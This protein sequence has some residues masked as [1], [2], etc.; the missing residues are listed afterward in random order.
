M[1]KNFLWIVLVLI[2]IVFI[3]WVTK[4]GNSGELGGSQVAGSITIAGSSSVQP[5]SEILAEKFMAQYTE[6]RVNV[7]GGGSSQGIES[8]KSGV[9]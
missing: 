3:T 6:A 5:F 2:L 7:Q 1:R 8:V 4:Y 9:A